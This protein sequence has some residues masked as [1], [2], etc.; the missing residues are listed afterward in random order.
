MNAV[1]FALLNP[2]DIEKLSKID[3][4]KNIWPSIAI[5]RPKTIFFPS[6]IM[7]LV[8]TALNATQVQVAHS[9]GLTGKGIKV[10]VIDTG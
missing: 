1:S 2:Q 4:V 8:E 7:P 10:G 6:S 9:L 3:I 5:P